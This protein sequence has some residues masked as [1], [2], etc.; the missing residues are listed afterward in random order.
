VKGLWKIIALLVIFGVL[1]GAVAYLNSTRKK[2]QTQLRIATTTKMFPGLEEADIFRIT[3][4]DIQYDSYILRKTAG[5]W[6]I[7]QG[8]SPM[9]AIMRNSQKDENGN[10]I[11][12]EADPR[13]D[14]GPDGDQYRS[15]YKADMEKVTPII[16]TMKELESGQ[17]VTSKPEEKSKLG[18][19]GSLMGTEIHVYDSEN[20]EVV[21][22][23]LG[24][25]EGNYTSTYIR[26][27]DSDEIYRVDGNA[28]MPFQKKV[29]D[30]RDRKLFDTAPEAI[31][32]VN[33]TDN[34]NVRVYS[35]TRVDLEFKGSM[36][37]GTAITLDTAKVDDLL[38][39]LGSLSVASFVNPDEEI[40]SPRPEGGEWDPADPFG[41]RIP[42]RIITYTDAAG[43][44]FTLNVG[45]KAGSNYYAIIADKPMDIF[46][47]S[48]AKIN[49]ISLDPLTLGPEPETTDV[50]TSPGVAEL[51][52]G[53][54]EV[55]E[56]EE[57]SIGMIPP[58]SGG[59]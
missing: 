4:S 33:V 3:V 7:A 13:D 38:S 6:E 5:V 59:E 56:L 26:K 58:P 48:A 21:G 1:F 41:L 11:E 27:P 18:V 34:E 20:N 35:L 43:S 23:I 44:T 52:P 2:E 42:L 28:Y 45:M 49:E 17:L 29:G 40:R 37:D 55:G 9:S 57:G 53:V 22:V 15:Y 30:F 46:K 36:A 16:D 47:V 39:S 54:A 51:P 8:P 14:N 24:A 31:N 50:S 10:P 12:Q 25:P 19:M 32:S